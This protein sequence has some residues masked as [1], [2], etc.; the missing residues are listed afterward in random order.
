MAEKES[1]KEWMRKKREKELKKGLANEW[2]FFLRFESLFN[3][4][5]HKRTT[6]VEKLSFLH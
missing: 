3:D 4:G 1:E 5:P 6:K 2:G